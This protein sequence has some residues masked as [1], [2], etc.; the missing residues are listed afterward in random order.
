[1]RAAE[2]IVAEAAERV[3]AAER[4]HQEKRLSERAADRVGRRERAAQGDDTPLCKERNELPQV[5]LG[6]AEAVLV[7]AILVASHFEAIPAA[8]A[9]VARLAVIDF[10]EAGR[11]LVVG[12]EV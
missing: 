9:R 12:V 4:G 5:N 3:V 1:M 10:D 8:L 6:L 7:A 11:G 2:A